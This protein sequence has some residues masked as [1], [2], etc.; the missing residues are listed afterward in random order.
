[1]TTIA[2]DGNTLAADKMCVNN[3]LPRTTTKI[4]KINNRLCFGSGDFDLLKAMYDWV[5]GGMDKSKYPERQKLDASTSSFYIIEPD[6]T[7]LCFEREPHPFPIQDLFVA[8]GS[9][10]DF[11]YAAMYLGRSAFEAVEIASVFDIN[12]GMGIDVLRHD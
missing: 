5:D 1:M 9:G 10:R 12:T 4:V 7:I 6:K 8:C 3:G 11:A 2:W